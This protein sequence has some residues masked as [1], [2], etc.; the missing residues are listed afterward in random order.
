M[1]GVITSGGAI[2][3]ALT[4]A[5]QAIQNDAVSLIGDA[6]PIALPIMGISVVLGIV[7][8]LFKRFAR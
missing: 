4:G 7:I 1:N 8:S 2:E 6:L 3:T 5:F